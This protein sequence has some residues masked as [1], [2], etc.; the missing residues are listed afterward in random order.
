LAM[1]S[2][3]FSRQAGG[4]KPA[5]EKYDRTHPVVAPHSSEPPSMYTEE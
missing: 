3:G 2:G 1:W 5:P 4:S